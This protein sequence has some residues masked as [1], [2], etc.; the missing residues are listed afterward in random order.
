[1]GWIIVAGIVGLCIS[2][3]I[4]TEFYFIAVEKGHKSIRYFCYC[5][6]FGILGWCMVAALPDRNK[7]YMASVTGGNTQQK[8]NVGEWQCTC[9]RVNK[10]YVYSCACGASK[11]DVTKK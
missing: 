1:M 5:F 11:A 6:F 4:A 7:A 9:G 8:A 10:N 2:I 3:W